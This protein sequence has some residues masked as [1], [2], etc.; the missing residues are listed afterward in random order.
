LF[1]QVKRHSA[2]TMTS[3]FPQRHSTITRMNPGPLNALHDPQTPAS[4]V[5]DPSALAA[6]RDLD[7]GGQ[8]G[9]LRRVL[10]A[11]DKSLTKLMGQLQDQ[12][13]APVHITQADAVFAVAH[14]L[15]AP[16]ASCGATQLARVCR[17]MEQKYRPSPER[18]ADVVADLRAD[19]TRLL[20]FAQ[21]AQAAVRAML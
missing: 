10:A 9:V 17:D 5:L 18:R 7:P 11:F 4:V 3:A 8:S 15:K 19:V 21:A 2:E 12:F 16:A 6:L 14:Q 1:S 20:G 13:E